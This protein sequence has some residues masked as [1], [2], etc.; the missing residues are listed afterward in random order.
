MVLVLKCLPN[1]E[2]RKKRIDKLTEINNKFENELLV[3]NEAVK[4]ME[5]ILS[6]KDRK[7]IG[8]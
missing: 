8:I 6:K 1:S 5:I 7:E 4:E 2:L 3:N